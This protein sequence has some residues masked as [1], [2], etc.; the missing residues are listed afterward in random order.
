MKAKMFSRLCQAS[1]FIL[2]GSGCSWMQVEKKRFAGIVH[3]TSSQQ[4]DCGSVAFITYSP[5]SG[6]CA[7]GAIQCVFAAPSDATHR[8]TW[9]MKRLKD[10]GYVGRHLVGAGPLP[11]EIVGQ[12]ADYEIQITPTPPN[13]FGDNPVVVRAYR[14]Q[15]ATIAII[16]QSCD[17]KSNP[18]K[19]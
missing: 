5:A 11:A 4:G 8:T 9:Q 13:T 14:G 6:A 17:N 2:L 19:H 18:P 3:H 15:L 7:A 1:A 12:S 16:Y 10:V